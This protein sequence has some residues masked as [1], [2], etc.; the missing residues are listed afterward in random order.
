MRE[1]YL[2]N[3]P[4]LVESLAFEYI[5]ENVPYPAIPFEETASHVPRYLRYRFTNYPFS[6]PTVISFCNSYV[7]DQFVLTCHR[8]RIS[9][10]KSEDIIC[11]VRCDIKDFIRE[12]QDEVGPSWLSFDSL[13]CVPFFSVND[14]VSY[15]SNE[16]TEYTIRLH[17]HAV[18][19]FKD[20]D[21][22][23]FH[24]S[25]HSGLV[26]KHEHTGVLTMMSEEI[27]SY[28]ENITAQSGSESEEIHDEQTFSSSK[29]K[30]KAKYKSKRVIRAQKVAEQLR[31]ANL[32]S[33]KR[34]TKTNF[35]KKLRTDHIKVQGGAEIISIVTS[36]EKM[37]GLYFIAYKEEKI[38][39]ALGVFLTLFNGSISASC[40][41]VLKSL[42][43]VFKSSDSLLTDIVDWFK[44]L[45]V[46]LETFKNNKY[47]TTFTS[48][49]YKVY[50]F[51]VCP[52]LH[53]KITSTI[54]CEIV[55]NILSFFEGM[56]FI[57]C[58]IHCNTYILNAIDVFVK[59]GSLQG[60][61]STETLTDQLTNK[62]RDIRKNYNL[63]RTG[64]L[65]FITGHKQY[66]FLKDVYELLDE[67]TKLRKTKK[68]VELKFIDDWIKEL[69]KILIECAKIEANAS[70]RPQP[71]LFQLV[72]GSG[73]SKSF[74]TTLFIQTIA[75]ANGIPCE[76]EYTFYLNQAN[77][78]QS[79][80]LNFK[81][82][83]VVDDAA[84]MMADGP[85]A[86]SLVNLADFILR[87]S[88]NVPH[89][90]LG[91]SI[92][93]KGTF[94]NRAMILGLNSNSTS[95]DFHKHANQVSALQRR[96]HDKIVGKVRPDYCKTCTTPSGKVF[97]TQIDYSKMTEEER[98]SISPDAWQFTVYRTDIQDCPLNIRTEFN[99]NAPKDAQAEW[100]WTIQTN[101]DGVV[102]DGISLEV[103]L[104]YLI[105][106]TREHYKVQTEVLKI[107][108]KVYDTNNYCSHGMPTM[109]NCRD[110]GLEAIANHV[111]NGTP[112]VCDL[113]EVD[114]ELNFELAQYDPLKEVVPVFKPI[115]SLLV[116]DFMEQALMNSETAQFYLTTQGGQEDFANWERNVKYSGDVCYL[117]S[118][119]SDINSMQTLNIDDLMIR[120]AFLTCNFQ[121]LIDTTIATVGTWME[122]FLCDILREVMMRIAKYI[123]KVFKNPLDYIPLYIEGT[124]LGAYLHLKHPAYKVANFL[125]YIS[126]KIKAS[127]F[128][129]FNRITG[130]DLEMPEPEYPWT[131]RVFE[132]L[133]PK[134]QVRQACGIGEFSLANGMRLTAYNKKIKEG[135]KD[136]F[137]DFIAPAAC[138]GYLVYHIIPKFVKRMQSMYCTQQMGHDL[139]VAEIKEMDNVD[140]SG[141]YKNKLESFRPTN[142]ASVKIRDSELINA[143]SRN[144]MYIRNCFTRDMINGFSVGNKFILIPNHF[145]AKSVG[146]TLE[147]IK[148]PIVSN[149][150]ASNQMFK[151]D[152]DPSKS[153]KL[154]GDMSLL[155]VEKHMDHMRT[156]NLLQ[157]F[158]NTTASYPLSGSLIRRNIKGEIEKISATRV[159]YNATCNTEDLPKGAIPV[160][161]YPGYVYECDSYVGLCGSVLV[162]ESCKFSHIV[163]MHVGGNVENKVGMSCYISRDSIEK[164]MLHFEPRGMI[165]QSGLDTTAYGINLY[166]DQVYKKS[167][168]LDTVDRCDEIELLGTIV[169]RVTVDNRVVQTPIAADVRE[170]FGIDHKWVSPPIFHEG[171][172]RY[173]VR[174]LL[175]KFAGR[176]TNIPAPKL[177][178]AKNDYIAGISKTLD[179]NL[180][181]WKKELFILDD[182]QVV[183]GIPNKRFVGGMNMSTSMGKNLPGS[184]SKYASQRDDGSW[185]LDDNIM[186]EY[187]IRDEKIRKRHLTYEYV[188]QMPKVE[189]TLEEKAEEGKIRNFFMAP[190]HFQ[191]LIRKYFLTSCRFWCLCGETTEC[192]VG[193]NPHSLE[194]DS[195]TKSIKGKLIA[196]DFKD[197]DIMPGVE[198]LST[199]IDI[200]LYPILT[201][202]VLTEEDRNAYD[203]LKHMLLYSICDANGDL[204]CLPGIIPSGTNIT[205]ILGCIINSLYYRVAF[206]DIY[207][208]KISFQEWV[209][210][211]TFGD[212]SIGGVHSS[213]SKFN[214]SNI[215]HTWKKYG[216]NGTDSSK[217]V[218]S[219]LKF[220][221]RCELEFLKRSFTYSYEFG[222]YIA[223]LEIKSMFKCLSC[224]VPPR[225]MTIEAVTGQCVDN[226]MMEAKFH[227][228][229]YYES[230]REKLRIICEKHDITKHCLLLGYDY[231]SAVKDWKKIYKPEELVTDESLLGKG[232]FMRLFSGETMP[233]NWS[234]WTQN[235][236]EKETK[237]QCHEVSKL[238][239]VQE[240]AQLISIQSGTESVQTQV[241]GLLS[242]TEVSAEETSLSIGGSLP[243]GRITDSDV[244]LQAFL[245]RPV[246][247]ASYEWGT[248]NFSETLDPW[249]ELLKNPRIANRIS[250]YELFRAKCHVKILINGN[251]FYYGCIMVS[252]LPF[253]KIDD[254]TRTSA[255]VARNKISLS[256]LPR[257][258]LDPTLSE[259]GE[260]TLPFFFPREYISLT[261]Q[262]DI[263]RP[264]SLHFTELEGLKHA[265]QLIS[266]SQQTVSI[267]VFAWFEDVE[268]YAPTHINMT[269]LTA[270]SGREEE[271]VNKPVSQAA[272]AVANAASVLTSVPVIAP[273]ALSVEKGARIVS[274][275]ASAFGYSNPVNVVE[276]CR[277]QPRITDNTAVT[278]CTDNTMKL[279]TDIKQELSIDNRLLGLDADDHMTINKIASTDSYNAYIDWPVGALPGDMI[280][281]TYVTP[282][283]C[284]VLTG[285]DIY[286][287]ASCGAAMPF[288][289]WT[290][291][292]TY[293]FKVVSSSFHRGRI[294]L[295]YDPNNIPSGGV[296]AKLLQENNMAYTHIIDISETREF[297]ITIGNYQSQQWLAIEDDWYETP[298]WS[299]TT[300]LNNGPSHTNGTLSLIVLNELT[301]PV[302]DVAIN[303]DITILAF[304]KAGSDFQ[305]STPSGRLA[306]YGMSV[307]SG[308]EVVPDE[309]GN[310]ESVKVGDHSNPIESRDMRVYQGEVISS[311]R[312]LLKRYNAYVRYEAGGAYESVSLF[313]VG[314][315]Y[316]RARPNNW[317][318]TGTNQVAN[319]MINYLLPAFSAWKGSIRYK[320]L[321][322]SDNPPIAGVKQPVGPTTVS[323]A[324]MNDSYMNANLATPYVDSKTS[325]HTFVL[326]EGVGS[327]NGLIF[328]ESSVNPEIEFEMPF[329]SN[330]KFIAGKPYVPLDQHEPYYNQGF[331]LTLT[332]SD[333][334]ITMFHRADIYVS[335]GEDFNLSF[336]TGWP[337]F[338][339]EPAMT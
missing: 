281:N 280:Y 195:L 295:V 249:D 303:T 215:L 181:Y 240:R 21:S 250:N 62:M 160:V 121:K 136:I 189:A 90:L 232:T 88:N 188:H 106:V 245:S 60:F 200:L 50:T 93:E 247:I 124:V 109:L 30:H 149:E 112:L 326:N 153:Y 304:S 278:N 85:T 219:V 65:E 26:T 328:T 312:T 254:Q 233:T 185:I 137:R 187:K 5:N 236:T 224:H 238:I 231:Y 339:T 248:V 261:G 40:L 257:I 272:T 98:N 27:F 284:D 71:Y 161:S 260:M 292:M 10:Y 327:Q 131:D 252:Y 14:F 263:N 267:T 174:T 241:D 225:F 80:W 102:M 244:S 74:L 25:L 99:K 151:M 31:G 273:Y 324:R 57:T 178:R 193:I 270:Q 154:D 203:T 118:L 156:K 321:I 48:F 275:V 150:I 285:K 206:F 269:G 214:I 144:V 92:E 45:S 113:D 222:C 159:V 291:S 177:N 130:A 38:Y 207:P 78:Y 114:E 316:F 279:T 18:I 116:Q 317:P 283:M 205:S 162:D 100:K 264:G 216:I 297:E 49:M 58:I 67:V 305:V 223:P 309:I 81:S 157:Y 3:D 138:G 308:T 332:N 47:A 184:K 183:N 56:D 335:A 192:A 227:G 262:S 8:M 217:N 75:K 52:S 141:W 277:F 307:Q 126:Y 299:R 333:P 24:V 251:G 242:F 198:V 11:G 105:D 82:N 191:M 143:V 286:A 155:Y 63:Y 255:L 115:P 108:K 142:L 293:R 289:Y 171:D 66:S 325:N 274:S 302:Y 12:L 196:T 300:F 259:G 179:K 15:I 294:A 265:N 73:I 319:T 148:G 268:V 128:E 32:G 89:E 337:P 23:F 51:F 96:I 117:Q 243:S 146:N 68:G 330:Y 16:R 111:S 186:E 266:V 331:L 211:R 209:S 4:Q 176:N 306:T 72:S 167:P 37:L 94:F 103:L 228:R 107:N 35:K 197:F 282:L 28:A 221:K 104:Q 123:E 53:D 2:G 226:F 323:V 290:G 234:S 170:A 97:S 230:S 1:V 318:D 70:A 125:D 101:S 42:I 13:N 301:T 86:A 218:D 36:L 246:K 69:D 7:S 202:C 145:L 175:R 288:K 336:F 84:A 164:A 190:T 235:F 147:F 140:T 271:T 91:A 9:Y 44:S 173:A 134:P 334:L 258:F 110:C 314:Y 201:V 229:K 76:P 163:G 19:L 39:K 276:P 168:V 61:L 139:S 237:D 315:P 46:D 122:E 329:Y 17:H 22:P 239:D 6:D 287:S 298:V 158:P 77:K 135:S 208:S 311:F 95:L 87:A 33:R 172:K 182:E 59:T 83:I 204:V 120:T 43:E 41:S 212:D 180:D 310:N 34:R 253:S 132:K 256:Q 64:D 127:P 55:R 320:I 213:C 152:Y 210:L 119:V 220:L 166:E 322:R 133:S 169:K 20:S 338:T 165:V 194:W 296:P 129:T 199:A 313:H 79:G 29:N 54:D